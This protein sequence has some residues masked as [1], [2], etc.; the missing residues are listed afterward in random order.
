VRLE[1]RWPGA[2]RSVTL[3]PEDSLAHL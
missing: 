1:L 2:A 3:T